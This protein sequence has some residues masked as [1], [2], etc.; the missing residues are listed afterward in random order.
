MPIDPALLDEDKLESVEVPDSAIH[1]L[2]DLIL[3]GQAP[4]SSSEELPLCTDADSF[5]FTL[6]NA[7]HF[8]D[9]TTMND[10]A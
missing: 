4:R 3:P 1:E 9:D 10:E 6:A 8:N 2:T 7:R 5:M